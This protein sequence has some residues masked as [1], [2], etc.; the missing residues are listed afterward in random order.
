M[1]ESARETLFLTF[2]TVIEDVIADKRKNPKNTKTLDE[3]QARIN[4]G[5][6]V[7]DDFILWVNLVADAGDY[8]L[9]KGA[10]DEY[11]LEIIADPEDMMYF[12][13]GQYSTIKMM[14]TKNRFGKRRLRYKGGTSGR[15]MG[16]L[17][18]LPKILV[19]DKE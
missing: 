7:E 11:D 9:N 19:L 5:L 17:L 4:I 12:T 1:D 14:T 2:K 16:K 18:K 10:L 13:N 15:N 3:F 8:E 6:H